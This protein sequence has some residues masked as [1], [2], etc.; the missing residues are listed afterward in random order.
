MTE[1]NDIAHVFLAH[2]SGKIAQP[3]KLIA[4]CT[5]YL[6]EKELVSHHTAEVA[7]LQAYSERYSRGCGAYVAT[8]LTTRNAI[9]IRDSRNG[10][11]RVFTVA[12]LVDLARTPAIAS[13]P[14]PS[15]AAFLAG[16]TDAT[17][18]PSAPNRAD[19]N[20]EDMAA[21]AGL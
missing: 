5:S 20:P 8:D 12:E 17:P 9:F 14:V 1:L 13:L 19:A 4:A 10:T 7:T 21:V 2:H 3:E 6:T 15:R 16:N 18:S 11:M